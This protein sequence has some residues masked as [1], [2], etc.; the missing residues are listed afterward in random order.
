MEMIKESLTIEEMGQEVELTQ[1]EFEDFIS[2]SENGLDLVDENNN[3]IYK[4]VEQIQNLNLNDIYEV[5]YIEKQNSVK[6]L[7]NNGHINLLIR[8]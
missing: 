7:L 2:G 3:C 1:L 6:L 5:Y 8:I 4:T